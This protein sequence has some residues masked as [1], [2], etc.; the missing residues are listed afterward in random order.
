MKHTVKKITFSEDVRDD[1]MQQ[2]MSVLK[3]NEPVNNILC[4]RSADNFV[5]GI[6][7]A[8]DLDSAFNIC[9]TKRS[10]NIKAA[11]FDA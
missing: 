3:A 9:Q 7:N 4:A 5:V 10:D 6:S 8:F 11:Y 1:N 2:G